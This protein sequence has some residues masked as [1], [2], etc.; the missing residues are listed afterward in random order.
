M[1][2]LPPELAAQL[3]K[4]QRR[5]KMAELMSA[6][7][8]QPLQGQMVSG[9]Y[10]APSPLQGIAQLGQAYMGARAG[11]KADEEVA[12]IGTQYDDMRKKAIEDYIKNRQGVDP[13]VNA[14]SMMQPKSSR[15]VVAAAMGDPFT[16][17]IAK[18]DLQQMNRLEAADRPMSPEQMDQRLQLAGGTESF[19]NNP[20]YIKMPDGSIQLL[21]TSN[22]GN[23][24]V[25]GLP[26]G[27]EVI[28]PLNFQDMGGSVVA[29][30]PLTG[31]PVTEAEKTLAPGQTPEAIAAAAAAKGVGELNVAQYD[32]ATA[33]LD[34]V[35]K[36]DD[37]INHIETSDAITGLGA[38]MFKNLERVKTLMGSD[39][40]AG[41]VKDTELLDV[42]MGSEVFPMIKTLGIGAR[43]MDTPA[44][45]EFM[46][47]VLTG[48][49]S[50]NKETILEMAQLRRKVAQRAINRWNSRVE[51]GELDDFFKSTGITKRKLGADRATPA[52]APEGIDPAAWGEMTPE[53]RA[54]FQ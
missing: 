32:T 14:P 26:E 54:L 39:V 42:M 50:L 44:E 36:I 43:G 9:H 6:Q 19:G 3:R 4:A 52:D 16:A 10:V 18:M 11:R 47:K 45:R 15:D 51:D 27:A 21:Q 30:D 53:E 8:Q 38:E 12:G 5:E 23:A 24:N 41:K 20:Q 35:Q 34:N 49:L 17:D 7:S 29:N 40:A 31:R 13:G 48:E 22:R 46:R 37:L 28:R 33:A 2:N 1:N 25:V